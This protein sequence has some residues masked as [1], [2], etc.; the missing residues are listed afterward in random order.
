M[1][2]EDDIDSVEKARN[3]SMALPQVTALLS[4]M[5][6]LILSGHSNVDRISQNLC[7]IFEDNFS[8]AFD[9]LVENHP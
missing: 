8:P 6:T 3:N 4:L 9:L 7:D 1:S 5:L 2:D